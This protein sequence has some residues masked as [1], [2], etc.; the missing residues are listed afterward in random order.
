MYEKTL[1]IRALTPIKPS[2]GLYMMVK[3][4]FYQLKDIQTDED[5]CLKFY[6]EEACLL[7]PAS[8]FMGK[9]SFRV[10]SINIYF[11]IIR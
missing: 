9:D 7:I 2:A 5:F 4:H 1:G 8:A 6:H 3:I 10:V 11:H